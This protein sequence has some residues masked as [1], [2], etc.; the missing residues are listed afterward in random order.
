MQEQR[1]PPPPQLQKNET[2]SRTMGQPPAGQS[3]DL[4]GVKM[5]RRQPVYSSFTYKAYARTRGRKGRSSEDGVRQPLL[6]T[7]YPV[8]IIQYH[9]KKPTACENKPISS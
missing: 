6:S 4:Q 1:S 3:H 8:N 2:A 9:V 5:S 7:E